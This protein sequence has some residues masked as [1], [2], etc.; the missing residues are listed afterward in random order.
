MSKEPYI[1]A[2]HSAL[3]ARALDENALPGADCAA[4][5][6][7]FEDRLLRVNQV[8]NLTAI[9]DPAQVAL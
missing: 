8:M 2:D 1:P 7:E 9:T 4:R 6:S 5:L 3:I